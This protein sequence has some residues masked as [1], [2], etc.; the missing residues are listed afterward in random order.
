MANENK[1]EVLYLSYDGM[2]D[3]L[4]QSQVIPYLKGL[5]AKGYSISLVSFEKYERFD[6]GKSI[7]E[8][9]LKESDISWHPLKYTKRPPILSTVW[10]IFQLNKLV[11]KLHNEKHFKIVHCRGYITAFAGLKLKKEK[12]VKF[13]FDMRG[14]FADERVESNVWNR[15]N[16]IFNEVYKFFKRKEIDFFRNADYSVCLT[17]KGKSI[18]HQFPVLKSLNITIKVIPCCADLNHFNSKNIDLAKKAEFIK[19]HNILP[20]ETVISYLGSVGTW[21]MLEEM[22]DFYAVA[23][24]SRKMRFMFITHDNAEAIKAKAKTRGI[25]ENELII[26]ASTRQDLPT[27]MS[28]AKISIFFIKPVFSKQASSPTKMGEL[29]GMGI[30][31]ICNAGVGDVDEIVNQTCCG[32]LVNFCNNEEY[33]R[34]AQK[35]DSIINTNKQKIIDGAYQYYSLENGVERYE[36]VYKCILNFQKL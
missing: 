11:R 22:L 14:F 35:L 12:G 25:D 24:K 30:P 6:A 19:K 36:E 27:L 21:Y 32:E 29:M 2:T 20:D 9:I 3:P 33:S 7:I 4:G 26:Q 1:I 5:S 28:I 18:I 34:I 17:E 13:V 15:N 8:N 16:I 31:I 23:R 10:D